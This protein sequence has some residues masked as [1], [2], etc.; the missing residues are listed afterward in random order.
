MS[1]NLYFN[2]ETPITKRFEFDSGADFF[3]CSP[4]GSASAVLCAAASLVSG[5]ALVWSGQSLPLL[6]LICKLICTFCSL[7]V[8]CIPILYK[9]IFSFWWNT[10]GI[11]GNTGN[12][13]RIHGNTRE[14]TYS[15]AFGNTWEYCMATL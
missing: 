7:S 2:Q 4:S 10:L 3:D 9:S 8:S 12:T 1:I 11:H 6:Y 14:Y 5:L 13:L 15:H